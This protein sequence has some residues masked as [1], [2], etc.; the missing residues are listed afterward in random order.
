MTIQPTLER[1]IP[2]AGNTQ[3]LYRFVNGFG[4]SVVQ[5]PYTHGGSEGLFE[6]A[7]LRMTGDGPEDW[8][9]TYETPI[10]EDVLGYLSEDEVQATLLQ[11]RDLPQAGAR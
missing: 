8:E 6:L 4:A 10:T 9:L 5:G 1:T 11:I 7:V 2:E 3:R